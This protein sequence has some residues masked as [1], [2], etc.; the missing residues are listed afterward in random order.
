MQIASQ[1]E[2][3]L[4][5]LNVTLRVLKLLTNSNNDNDSNGNHCA[6]MNIIVLMILM[7]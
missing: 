1:C 5:A 6:T 4:D 7:L 2:L 3:A